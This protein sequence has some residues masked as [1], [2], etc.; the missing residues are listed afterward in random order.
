MKRWKAGAPVK[1]G[2]YRI[3]PIEATGSYR[4]AWG[5]RFCGTVF[6]RPVAVVIFDPQ[7]EALAIEITG[8][9][10][11]LELLSGEVEGLREW[12]DRYR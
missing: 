1:A 5:E 4:F 12:V 8:E 6:K 7:G 2:E 11:D 9:R 10:L 3:V